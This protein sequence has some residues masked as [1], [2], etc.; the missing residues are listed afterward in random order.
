MTQSTQPKKESD[1]WISFYIFGS[2]IVLSFVFFF[3][4]VSYF[5]WAN[6]YREEQALKDVKQ[7]TLQDNVLTIRSENDKRVY[8]FRLPP[9]YTISPS[10]KL[11]IRVKDQVKNCGIPCRYELYAFEGVFKNGSSIPFQNY[12]TVPFKDMPDK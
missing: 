8:F 12:H 2:I 1:F 4:F 10:D 3:A 6:R 7:Y 11:Q 9:T 5:E